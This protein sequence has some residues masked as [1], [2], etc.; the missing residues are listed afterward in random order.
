MTPISGTIGDC[1]IA[2][3]GGFLYLAYLFGGGWLAGEL[4][5]K[6]SPRGE[7]EGDWMFFGVFSL[8]VVSLLGFGIAGSIYGGGK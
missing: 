1:G 7:T 3:I 5:K 8:L 2:L 4:M 6:V